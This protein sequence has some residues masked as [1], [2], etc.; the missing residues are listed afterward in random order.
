MS[1]DFNITRCFHWLS[2][3]LY[4]RYTE[5]TSSLWSAVIYSVY[6]AKA[7][8]PCA[9]LYHPWSRCLR[10]HSLLKSYLSRL[11]V[12]KSFTLMTAQILIPYLIS[13]IEAYWWHFSFVHHPWSGC[14]HLHSLLKSYLSRLNVDKSFTLMTAQ[15]RIPYFISLIEAY[16]WHF[17]FVHHPWSGCLHLHSLLK[18]Y[19]SRLN[20]DKSFTLMTAQ[21][22]IPYFISL[23][24]AY[25]WHFSFVHHPWSG[26]LHLHSFF[27]SYLSR[28]NVDKSFTLMTA[29]IRIPYFVSLIEAY[30]WNLSFVQNTVG[31]CTV[32]I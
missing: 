13:L 5:Y 1:A 8:A 26:C 14:L 12:D 10:L 28:L 21:I 31:V 18:S 11:N 3:F 24:E 4:F 20:V 23:I 19:L 9:W 30:W 27:K 15:I 32:V 16:W 17:S 6:I 25:W 2:I 7:N 29:Q 22:L